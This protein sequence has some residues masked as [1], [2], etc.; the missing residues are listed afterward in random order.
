MG[1]KREM[2]NGVVNRINLVGIELE[3]GWDNPIDGEHIVHDGSVKFP[4]PYTEMVHDRL[5]RIVR[6][7]RDVPLPHPQ[8]E[9]GEIVS[10]PLTVNAVEE[11]IRKC[12]PQHVN[13]TCGLHVHMSFHYKL[14]YSRLMK[15]DYMQM[16]IEELRRFADAEQLPLDHNLRNR[17]NPNHPWT[18][19]HCAHTFLAD[20]QV[21]VTDKNYRSRGTKWSRY[22]FIN[23]CEKQHNTLECRGLCMFGT[24]NQLVTA[25]DVDVAV[26][27]VMTVIN[28]TNRYLSKMKQREKAISVSVPLMEP[29]VTEVARIVR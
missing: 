4:D 3:G 12:Y 14:N 17:L 8:Y 23:Y 28:T 2:F 10:R 22:T 9:K 24:A 29:A 20:N 27:A 7:D 25:A 15:P 19:E 11:W 6:V 21:Q 1:A 18:L 26:R 16:M 13:Q 5:G